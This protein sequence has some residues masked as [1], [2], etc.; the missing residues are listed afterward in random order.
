MNLIYK[1]SI[2]HTAPKG[3]PPAERKYCFAKDEFS[4]AQGRQ[5]K[6]GKADEVLPSL[7]N[8]NAILQDL[9][10]DVAFSFANRCKCVL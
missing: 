9:M 3:K 2:P 4:E 6:Q 1:Y 8:F 5:L 7:A 10:Q